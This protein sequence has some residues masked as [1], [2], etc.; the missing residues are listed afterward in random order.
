MTAAAL[1]Q[2]LKAG[3]TTVCRCWALARRDGR[4]LGFTDHDQA[5]SFDGIA[6]RA[7]TGLTARAVQ[8]STGLSVDNTEAVGVLSDPSISDAD[9]EAGR[10]DGAQVTAWLVNWTEPSQRMVQFRGTIGEIT[11]SAGGFRAELRGLAERLNEPRGRAYQ[12]RC[13]AVLG[14]A[15]CKVD[16]NVPQYELVAAPA[17]V[18]EERILSFEG[19]DTHAPGWFARGGLT[20]LTGAAE[21]L[22]GSVKNDSF[23]GSSRRIE[24]WEALRAPLGPGDMVR[25]TAG[26][27]KRS[28]TCRVKFGNFLN[29]RGFPHI[30]GDDWLM[31]YPSRGRRNDG[32]SLKR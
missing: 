5:L 24:L 27:D 13:G 14:D 20:V 21:G 26:C 11:R 9:V 10:Y 31:A 2:H 17:T 7:D 25:L 19:A 28:E 8:Q 6:F 3:T 12:P 22:R 23:E 1:T 30:P 16:L 29:F 18:L 15:A 4:V 32:G